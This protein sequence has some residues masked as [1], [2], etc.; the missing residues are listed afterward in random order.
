MY[1]HNVRF[2]RP[3]IIIKC[4]FA[5]NVLTFSVEM[6]SFCTYFS[7]WKSPLDSLSCPFLPMKDALLFLLKQ[8]LGQKENLI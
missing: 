8:P 5:L 4:I 3:K 1:T 7:Q 6:R 2:I